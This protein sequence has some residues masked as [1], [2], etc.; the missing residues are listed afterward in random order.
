MN[1]IVTAKRL[2]SQLKFLLDDVKSNRDAF[3]QSMAEANNIFSY[4]EGQLGAPT[5]SVKVSPA[6]DQIDAVVT[7][8]RLGSQVQF[9]LEVIEDNKDAYEKAL[10]EAY[11]IFNYKEGEP[12]APTVSV[13]LVPDDGE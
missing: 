10:S 5:V 2:G 13:E 8:R 11:F 9:A 12:G 1:A 7:A 4:K 6:T 3:E